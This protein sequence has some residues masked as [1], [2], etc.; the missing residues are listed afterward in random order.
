[1]KKEELKQY[2]RIVHA[3]PCDVTDTDALKNYFA[4][5]NEALGGLHILVNNPS[6]FG[7]GD[8]E[9]GWAKSID[10][11][12]MALVRSS[13][14]AIPLIESSG[15]GNIIHI[16]SISGL[17]GGSSSMVYGA[18]KAAVIHYTASQSRKLVAS[19]IRVNC[20][21]PGSIIFEGGLWEKAQ[22]EDPEFFNEILAECPFGRMGTPEEVANLAVF[23]AS[24]AARW[25][26]GQTITCDG[27]QSI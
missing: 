16:S 17:A 21:A 6:G 1:M 20:I 24:D 10:V 23:L 27:G 26:T 8:D 7:M 11:D 14:H 5:A 15:G 18:I 3:S 4:E 9:D 19:N 13:W 22:Q 12:L 2:G 25:I